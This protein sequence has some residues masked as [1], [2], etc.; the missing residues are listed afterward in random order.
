MRGSAVE[1]WIA[2]S[3]VERG[4]RV[5]G[6]G[7]VVEHQE[8]TGLAEPFVA[9][10]QSSLQLSAMRIASCCCPSRLLLLR[11]Q[12]G[13][14]GCPGVSAVSESQRKLRWASARPQPNPSLERGLSTAGRSAQTLGT[15]H[16]YR[17]GFSI[18]LF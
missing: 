14:S 8:G 7:A 3:S 18:L 11:V 4:G 17:A 5:P 10:R 15:A 12:T 2:R 6:A 16:E 1:A 13:R 9:R